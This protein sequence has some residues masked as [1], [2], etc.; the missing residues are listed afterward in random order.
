MCNRQSELASHRL[1]ADN[2]REALS[3][4]PAS[5]IHPRA[6]IRLPSSLCKPS[7]RTHFDWDDSGNDDYAAR[8]KVLDL[9]AG[10][11][12]AAVGLYLAGFNVTGVDIVPQPR[13][14]FPF[15]LADA[16]EVDLE[17]YDCY[18]ASPP[19]QGYS[20]MNNLPWLKGRDYPLLILPTLERLEATGKPYVLENVMG[21]RHGAKGLQKRGLE[22]HGLEAGYLCGAMFGKP[23][24]RH[25]LF[26]TNFPWFAPGH[27]KHR[28]KLPLHRLIKGMPL[29]DPT[30]N[31]RPR[32][33]ETFIFSKTE[34][35]RGVASW[36]NRRGNPQG[37]T[38]TAWQGHPGDGVAVGH[39]KGWR[40]AAE[41]MGIDWMKRE[42]LTQ[43]IP[44]IYAQYLGQYLLSA[45]LGVEHQ[46]VYSVPEHKCDT[47][48]VHHPGSR[49]QHRRV[50]G[51]TVSSGH[52]SQSASEG[53]EVNS[54]LLAQHPDVIGS[55]NED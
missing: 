19:C 20:I 49:S 16:I 36:P 22:A 34:D 2:E 17:G 12:G 37:G 25:R 43:A 38:L 6:R 40:L 14:P 24:Y 8:P 28:I 1:S 39:A 10:G 31:P 47:S 53:S 35:N 27:P 54:H 7:L 9:F 33:T 45:V 26:A 21:A 5:E 55:R 52:L 15:I 51:D 30:Q 18:W 48:D 44:P 13:Y 23:F 29:L 46:P 3:S 50:L 4:S 42:E 41:A 32:R 11:G